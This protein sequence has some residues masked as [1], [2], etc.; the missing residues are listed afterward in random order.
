MLKAWRADKIG[1]GE[2]MGAA[3][4]STGKAGLGATF[5]FSSNSLPAI[6]KMA[7]HQR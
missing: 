7:A 2:K 4:L 3:R 1:R 6:K 5:C